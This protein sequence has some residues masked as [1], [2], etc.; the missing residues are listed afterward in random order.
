MLYIY[1]MKIWKMLIYIFHYASMKRSNSIIFCSF[2]VL[3]LYNTVL[4]SLPLLLLIMWIYGFLKYMLNEVL[5]MKVDSSNSLYTIIR[6]SVLFVFLWWYYGLDRFVMLSL[7]HLWW[8]L[9]NVSEDTS[10]SIMIR[11]HHFV[12]YL[13][14][15]I[16]FYLIYKIR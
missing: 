2:Q 12:F 16:Y 3:K 1:D 13:S 7:C 4:L 5:A 6:L 14:S 9:K 8:T 10:F 11:K 15:Q